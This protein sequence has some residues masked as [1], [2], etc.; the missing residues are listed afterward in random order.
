MPASR[1]AAGCELAAGKLL[2]VEERIA[3]LF[4]LRDALR[5]T[6][7]QWDEQLTSTSPD[8]MAHLLERMNR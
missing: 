7:A 1:R 2:Q 5:T 3:D 6:I 8:A 4:A